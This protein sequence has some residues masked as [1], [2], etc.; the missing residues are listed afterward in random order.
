MAFLTPK[1]TAAAVAGTAL[2]ITLLAACSDAYSV[3]WTNSCTH[4]VEFASTALT[5]AE[6]TELEVGDIYGGTLTLE[7]FTL[8]PDETEGRAVPADAIFVMV[9]TVDGT[10]IYL[11]EQTTDHATVDLGGLCDQLRTDG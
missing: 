9:T 7:R 1:H 8:E 2:A 5:P 3:D 6:R 11:E 4:Q 10:I